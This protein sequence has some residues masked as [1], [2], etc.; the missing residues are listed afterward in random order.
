MV[1]THLR[2]IETSAATKQQP[3]YKSLLTLHLRIAF[4]ELLHM[5]C[6]ILLQYLSRV[7]CLCLAQQVDEAVP[8]CSNWQR[9]G[10]WDS[11][12]DKLSK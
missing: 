12:V 2:C 3:Q 9:K 7:L 6:A 5:Q 11:Y 1:L 4:F 8:R 10:P